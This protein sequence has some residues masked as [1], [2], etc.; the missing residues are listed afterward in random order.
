MLDRLLPD[1]QLQP[2]LPFG[3]TP[4]DQAWTA[5]RLHLQP[6]QQSWDPHQNAYAPSDL[7]ACRS[8]L[9]RLGDRHYLTSPSI[10]AGRTVARA[11]QRACQQITESHT[12][13]GST[14]ACVGLCYLG[15][16]SMHQ[17]PEHRPHLLCSI[18]CGSKAPGALLVHLGSGSHSVCGT[19]TQGCI[20]TEAWEALHTAGVQP[21]AEARLACWRVSCQARCC[22]FNAD[23]GPGHMPCLQAAETGNGRR[24][25]A[26]C[27]LERLR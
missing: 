9:R 3:M 11:Q 12:Y 26:E 16:A 7:A 6:Q 17:A 19:H 24:G 14:H 15:S 22:Q 21:G 8:R 10:E 4:Q 27:G 5:G 13:P 23:H 2:L 18:L 20:S 25:M 1:G